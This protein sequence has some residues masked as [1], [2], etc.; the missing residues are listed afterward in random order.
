[1]VEHNGD[2]SLGSLVAMRKEGGEVGQKQIF[3]LNLAWKSA[4]I[5]DLWGIATEALV[6]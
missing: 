3:I 5:L 4:G 2:R 1:M 6:L